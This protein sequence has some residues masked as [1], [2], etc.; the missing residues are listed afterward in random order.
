VVI[1]PRG[2]VVA[3]PANTEGSREKAMALM[4]G[5]CPGG[6]DITREEEAVT[7]RDVTEETTYEY[8][9]IREEVTGTTEYRTRAR[10]EWRIH[11]TCR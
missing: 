6:Y 5:Q 9:R 11:F 3:L 1:E 2:G 8:S 7:G 10:R 4:A